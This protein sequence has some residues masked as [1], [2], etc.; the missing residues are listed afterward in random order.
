[1]RHVKVGIGLRIRYSWF[2]DGLI[3]MPNVGR[4]RAIAI[5][6]YRNSSTYAKEVRSELAKLCAKNLCGEKLEKIAPDELH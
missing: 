3:L 4:K 6:E 5:P 1:M 2:C